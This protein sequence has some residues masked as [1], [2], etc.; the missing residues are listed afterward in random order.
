VSLVELAVPQG[1]PPTVAAVQHVL[2][3]LLSPQHLKSI[4]S[5]NGL[6]RQHATQEGLAVAACCRLG[7]ARDGR[8]RAL[9]ES[10]LRSQWPD[11][12]WNCDPRE[13]TTHSSFHETIGPL[14]GLGEY[15]R[16]TKG[17]TALRAGLA[18]DRAAEFLL[19]HRLFRSHTTGRIVHGEFAKLHYPPYWHY[20]VLFGLLVL[21]R[22]GRVMDH[23]AMEALDL[24]ES[25]RCENG[26]WR[27]DGRPY[28][29]PPGSE[30]SNVEVVDWGRRGPNQMVTIKALRVLRAA[31]RLDL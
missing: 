29:R 21:A 25:K 22:C 14:W 24:V 26:L 30:G 27:A 10:M 28:W 18:A 8:T 3:W 2:G 7:M 9:V 5:V 19:V 23:R 13:E 11:G 12:G 1:D 17:E 6:V 16:A 31:G 20:D 4:R 15:V